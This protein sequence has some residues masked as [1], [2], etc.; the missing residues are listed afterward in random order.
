MA[1]I[2]HWHVVGRKNID[3]MN[4]LIA[5]WNN[6]SDAMKASLAFTLSS[7]FVK[8]ISFITTPVFTRIMDQSQYGVISTYNA[9]CTVIEVLAVLGMTSAGIINVGLNDYRNSRSQYLSN[10]TVLGNVTTLAVFA[11]LFAINHIS[12][13]VLAISDAL[14]GVM[15][16]HFLFYPAQ[17]YW[18]TRQRYELR[19]KA[20][21]AVSILSVVISQVL[22]V[23][24][25]LN[26]TSNQGFVK[27][28]ANE[29]GYLF[30]AIPLYV[31]LLIRGKSYFNR[32]I[33]KQVLIFAIPLIPHYLAQHLMSSADRIMIS[34]MVSTADTGIYNLVFNVGWLATLVW[35]AI[36]ASLTP[37]IYDKLNTKSYQRTK[38]VTKALIILYTVV[39]AVAII[40]AP[41]VIRIL[42]PKD[43]YEGVY[44]IPPIVGVAF[45]T[46]L[47]NLYAN[48]E[49]YY[50]KTKY[51]AISTII[52][53]FINLVLNFFMIQRWSYIG[54]SYAT[55]ISYAILILL[56]YRGYRKAQPESVY[57]DEFFLKWTL[58]FIAMCIMF[59]LLY[60]SDILRYCLFAICAAGI[61]IKR[62]IVKQ[63]IM[64]VRSGI[65]TR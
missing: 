12:G 53:A 43:Y 42:A 16:V 35:T 65:R 50:K 63:Y 64:E 10:I 38:D 15:L 11:I 44:A 24:F 28:V 9:W 14:L 46:G 22:A 29:V 60:R 58:V 39:C 2:G 7:F 61:I 36:N 23:V 8:G 41:E 56:H 3:M 55:L 21:T 27:I 54:A 62:N 59:T 57:Y 40:L 48:V 25:A 32:D 31:L 37:F 5:K 34:N 45:L 6:L 52:A 19:Y 17:I 18:L 49:F 20:A 51:I 33:W 26:A 13:T 1:K 4:K 30:M 47:Y